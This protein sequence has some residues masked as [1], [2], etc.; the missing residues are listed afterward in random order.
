MPIIALVGLVL[1][2][3]VLAKPVIHLVYSVSKDAKEL[4]TL[5]P[6][7]V[8][9]ASRLNQ[10]RVAEVWEV[11]VD[12]D[13]P[14][15]QIARLLAIVVVLQIIKRHRRKERRQVCKRLLSIHNSHF[16]FGQSI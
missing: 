6:D 1:L 13:D 16:V 15:G 7:Y 14:E 4:A 5:P 3:G 8:D 11:P 10:T 2:V 12:S 9:D